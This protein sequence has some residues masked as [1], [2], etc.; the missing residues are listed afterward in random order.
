MLETMIL[1]HKLSMKMKKKL[2]YLD[3]YKNKLLIQLQQVQHSTLFHLK[4][5]ENITLLYTCHSAEPH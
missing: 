5:T 1:I 4:N 2:C 3:A